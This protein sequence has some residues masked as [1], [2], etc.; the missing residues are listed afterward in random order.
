MWPYCTT[1]LPEILDADT[2]LAQSSAYRNLAELV[3]AGV[4]RRIVTS[5]EY[6]Y[7]EIAERLTG[8]H[9][10]H[11]ICSECGLVKDFTV[12]NELEALIEQAS[13]TVAHTEGWNVEHHQL[14]LIGRCTRCR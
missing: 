1:Q 13:T 8:E 14:D 5:D 7:F 2:D 4:V 10:H 11:L 12:P 3:D 6:S 9:H